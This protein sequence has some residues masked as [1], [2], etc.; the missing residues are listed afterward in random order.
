[1][2]VTPDTYDEAL[3]YIKEYPTWTVDVETNGFNWYDTNQICGIG[4]GVGLEPKTFYFPFRHF[5]SID[6]VN[7][8]PPQLFQL[9]ETMNKCKTLIGYN[10]KFDLHFLENEGL[11]VEDKTLIDV[12]VLIRLTEPSDVREKLKKAIE[13]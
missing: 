2:L 9:M 11:I 6:S 13:V 12:I 8:H 1:M 4:V 10:V 5:P 7:L 3:A